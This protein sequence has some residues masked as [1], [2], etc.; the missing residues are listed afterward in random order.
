VSSDQRT[1]AELAQLYMQGVRRADIGEVLDLT[2][3]EVH[4]VLGELFAEG[5]PKLKR[6]ALSDEK[7]RAIHAAYVR[8]VNRSGKVGG[9]IA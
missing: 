7:V 1:R 6:R 4:K 9:L 8:G 3:G 5:M 2:R